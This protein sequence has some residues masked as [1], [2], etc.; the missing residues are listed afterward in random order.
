MKMI[1]GA[2]LIL[3]AAVLI[4]AAM[5]GVDIRNSTSAAPYTESRLGYLLG[6]GLALAGLILM[7]VGYRGDQTGPGGA[8]DTTTS[9]RP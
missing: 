6:G 1:A 7:A 8:S 5:L 9:A 4:S 2:I 3:A